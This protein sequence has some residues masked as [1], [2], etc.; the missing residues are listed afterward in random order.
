[1]RKTK[2]EQISD[3]IKIFMGLFYELFHQQ[4]FNKA[5]RYINLLK[6]ELTNFPKMMQDYLNKNF[7]PVYR[8]YLIFLEKLFIGKLESLTTKQK[9]ISEIQQTNTQKESTE[10][11]NEYLTTLWQEKMAGQKIK[12]S[13][14]KLTV[15]FQARAKLY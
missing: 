9:I 1:M 10:L 13:P 6:Q 12:K 15:L 14:N 3:E 2:K 7:F 11:Q 4:T 5:I 8:K